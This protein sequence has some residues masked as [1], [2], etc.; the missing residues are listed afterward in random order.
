[1]I[2]IWIVCGTIN[3][4]ATLGDSMPGPQKS[5][6]GSYYYTSRNYYGV[7]AIMALCGPIGT[8][9]LLFYT[10]FFQHGFDWK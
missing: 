9:V 2:C 6:S 3:W 5:P 10:N 1:M 4:G 7:S 8:V